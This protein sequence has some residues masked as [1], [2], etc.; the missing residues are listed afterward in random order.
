M[1]AGLPADALSFVIAAY[2]VGR[3]V[4]ATLDSLLAAVRPGDEIIVVDDGSSDDTAA[5]VAAHPAATLGWLRL[6]GQT[7]QGLA[8]TR[9][10]GLR[11]ATRPYVL[12]FDGDDLLQAENLEPVRAA[13]REQS[14]DVVLFDFHFYWAAPTERSE[15]SPLR[16]HPS[17]TLLRDPGAWLAQAYD[18]AITAMW[19]R[20]VRR[21]LYDDVLPRCCPRWAIYEDLAASP[22]VL[23]A[24]RSLLYLPVPVVRY[25]Q[26]SGS[27]TAIRSLD[28]SENLLRSALFAAEACSALPPSQVVSDAAWRM[29]ARKVVEAIRHA[30]VAG[31]G[32]DEILHRLVRPALRAMGPGISRVTYQLRESSRKGDRRVARHLAQMRRWPSLYAAYRVA[33]GLRYRWRRRG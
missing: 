9:L 32:A 18:D 3:H 27:L 22:H 28:A 6:V 15:R 16:T 26:R 13:L 25:R 33:I 8:T 21:E 2:D 7:N 5:R 4:E 11:Q 19:S 1:S 17:G 23:A 31:A 29:V 20:V 24:A 14:P 10:N 30:V 12:F